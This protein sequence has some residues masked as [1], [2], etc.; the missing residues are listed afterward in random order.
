MTE[1]EMTEDEQELMR[2]VERFDDASHAQAAGLN[3][4]GSSACGEAV[5]AVLAHYRKAKAEATD[6]P[7]CSRL[8]RL[9]EASECVSCGYDPCMCDQQ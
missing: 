7:T 1:Q 2:L 5:A 3:P 4:P 6:C 9:A 8:N